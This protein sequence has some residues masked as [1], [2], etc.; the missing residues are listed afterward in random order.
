[1]HMMCALSLQVCSLL[2][3]MLVYNNYMHMHTKENFEYQGMHAAV[4]DH[5]T[6]LI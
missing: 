6:A 4:Q 5:G 1:M 3:M 2:F